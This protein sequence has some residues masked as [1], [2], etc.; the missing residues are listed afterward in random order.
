M[1]RRDQYLAYLKTPHWLS[2]KER[3]NRRSGR[4]CEACKRPSPNAGQ[5]EVHHL[6]YGDA[7]NWLDVGMSDLAGLC[8]HCHY[9]VHNSPELKELIDSTR[10]G[11][12]RLNA[13]R[14]AMATERKRPQRRTPLYRQRH[15]FAEHFGRG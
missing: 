8:R 15:E 10:R 4:I 3:V 9:R 5:L 14:D 6:H 1:T 2:L 12:S 11:F 7:G 13:L